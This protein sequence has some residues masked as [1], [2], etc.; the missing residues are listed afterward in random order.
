MFIGSSSIKKSEVIN[1]KNTISYINCMLSLSSLETIFTNLAAGAAQTLT[2]TGNWGA[3][4]L[5]SKATIASTANS[6]TVPVAATTGLLVG[7]EVYGAFITG[8][9]TVTLTTGTNLLT[10]NAHALPA[11]QKVSFTTTAAGITLNT[12]YYVINPTANTFQISLTPGGAAVTIS[13]ST[14][15]AMRAYPKIV[16]V[17]TNVSIVLDIPAAATGSNTL[18]AQT[19]QRSIALLKGWTVTG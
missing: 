4:A 17:N 9:R 2:I 5:I 15:I 10:F 1:T 12:I 16:T 8:N 6:T 3:P 11:G 18:T 13:A 14:T 19:L 7:M